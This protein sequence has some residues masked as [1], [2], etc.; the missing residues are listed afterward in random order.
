VPELCRQAFEAILDEQD[1]DLT[2]IRPLLARLR[3]QAG[4]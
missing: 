3:E 1:A 2:A 4:R